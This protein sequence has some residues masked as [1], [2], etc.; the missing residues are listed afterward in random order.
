MMNFLKLDKIIQNIHYYFQDDHFGVG[1]ALNEHA[2]GLP[3]VARGKHFVHLNSV[4][5]FS[6]T[7][8]RNTAQELYLSPM[9]MFQSSEQSLEEWINSDLGM[10]SFSALNIEGFPSEVNLMTIENWDE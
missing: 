8:R 4:E 10:K 2:Y 6:S 1:E 9:V 5:P 7:W 3:L